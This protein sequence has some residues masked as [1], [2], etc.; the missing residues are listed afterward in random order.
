MNK[1]YGLD[2]SRAMQQV[3]GW[4]ARSMPSSEQAAAAGKG[5]PGAGWPRQRPTSMSVAA[6]SPLTPSSR[7]SPAASLFWRSAR[8]RLAACRRAGVRGTGNRHSKCVQAFPARNAPGLGLPSGSGSSPACTCHTH[9][10]VADRMHTG[11]ASQ[12][13][14][15]GRA[16]AHRAAP[17]LQHTWQTVPEAA[18]AS[19]RKSSDI[20]QV[21]LNSA[22]GS[23]TWRM[24]ASRMGGQK[25]STCGPQHGGRAAWTGTR[26]GIAAN[27]TPKS[28]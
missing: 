7:P 28:I 15:A 21:R 3:P 14:A 18:V 19:M 16:P 13:N 1:K 8:S 12:A 25:N 23:G 26:V 6:R 22:E 17:S 27:P 11:R 5:W 20:S 2:P 9:L 10:K 4:V 24:S